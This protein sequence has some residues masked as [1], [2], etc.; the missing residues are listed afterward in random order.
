MEQQDRNRLVRIL[1]L[2]GSD[3]PGERAAAALQAH[4]LIS[5]LGLEW[6]DLVA[7]PPVAE[8]VVVRRVRDW[9]ID[10]R[11]AAEA[12]I[13]QLKSTTERQ[14]RQIQALR[15]RVNTLTDRER[16]RREREDEASP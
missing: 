3:Q 5:A 14:A 9:D 2:L 16:R 6:K 10:H 7:P 12:R 15:T 1:N 4:R 11:E 13:R 8:R